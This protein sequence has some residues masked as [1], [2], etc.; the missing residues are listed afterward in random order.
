M[1][2]YT[3]NQRKQ[4]KQVEAIRSSVEVYFWQQPVFQVAVILICILITYFLLVSGSI[5]QEQTIFSPSSPQELTDNCLGTLEDA[6]GLVDG[7]EK[8]DIQHIADV[9]QPPLEITKTSDELII[10]SPDRYLYG[11][12]RARINR[13]DRSLKVTGL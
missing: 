5:T 7:N 8:L 9:C 3:Q 2:E 11:F 4:F 10:I 1:Q 13:D 12:T 6:T